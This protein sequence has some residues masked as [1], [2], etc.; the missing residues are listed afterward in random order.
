MA[1]VTSQ[2][3]VIAFNRPPPTLPPSVQPVQVGVA[4]RVK[5]FPLQGWVVWAVAV[6][7]EYGV[8]LSG[9]ATS[10]APAAGGHVG[11]DV[12]PD[13]FFVGRN[14]EEAAGGAFGDQGVAVGQP[15]GAAYV[16]AVEG[17]GRVALVFPGDLVGGW[18]NLDHPGMRESRPVGAVVEYHYAPVVQE[19][20]VVLVGDVAGAPFP[21]E[22]ARTLINDADG[23]G[24]PETDQQVSIGGHG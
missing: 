14:L 22:F 23:A 21:G 18:V 19:S 7:A 12:F 8:G 4:G 16:V 20:G 24:L 1:S 15:L 11:I 9:D 2:V 13:D 6:D 5:V 17:Y 3:L 10:P